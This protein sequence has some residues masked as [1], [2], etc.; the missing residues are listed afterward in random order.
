MEKDRSSKV[1]AIVGLVVAVAALSVG[2]A[3]FTQNLVIKSSAEV[4]P[5]DT[6]LDVVFSSNGTS[7]KEDKVAANPSDGGTEKNQYGEEATIVNTG[8]NPTISGLHAVFTKKGQSVTYTFYVHNQSEYVAY[9]RSVTFA[10]ATGETSY[11]KCTAGED[12]TASMVAA[13]CADVTLKVSVGGTEFTGS[14]AS[15]KGNSIGVGEF[16]PVI[17]TISYDAAGTSTTPIPDGDF[18]IE[19]GDITLGYSSVDGK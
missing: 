4:N 1:I 9:L 3:A 14:N 10:N 11:K 19:F 16:S 5:S 13:A 8:T 12:T 7:Q 6:T 2:F 18:D 15:I 17:V